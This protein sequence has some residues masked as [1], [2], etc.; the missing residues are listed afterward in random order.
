[1]WTIKLL[2]GLAPIEI[3][4]ASAF[5]TRDPILSMGYHWLSLCM[6]HQ[7]ENYLTLLRTVEEIS[8][9]F[10]NDLFISHSFAFL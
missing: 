5:R 9:S 1:M 3:R 4:L 10:M 7:S 8:E 6:F 2:F